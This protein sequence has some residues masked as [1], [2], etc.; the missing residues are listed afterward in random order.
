VRGLLA[1]LLVASLALTAA[2]QEEPDQNLDPTDLV[3][4][5]L[6]GLLGFGEVSGPQL[7]EEVAQIGGVPFRSDVPLAYLDKPALSRYLEELFD[8]EY[9]Q[10]QADADARTLRGLDLL[11]P[12]TDL[13]ALRRR[14][15]LENVAG[16]YDERPG[17]RRLYAVST[18]QALTPANQIIMAHELRHA[19]QDQYADL[20]GLFPDSVGDFDDRKMALLC[21]LEGDATLVM[22]KFLLARVPGG[23]ELGG[24]ALALPTPPVDGA[25][26][27]LRDQL[28]RP[29]TLGLEFARSVQESRG[30]SALQQ[31]WASP[32]PSTEQI[33]HPEKF[34]AGERPVAVSLDWSPAGGRVLRDGVLGEVFAS[35]LVDDEPGNEAT[36]GWGGDVVRSW[37][38]AGRTL[39]VFRS[40]WDSEADRAQ[41]ATALLQRFRAH[42]GTGFPRGRAQVFRSGAW[43]F[44]LTASGDGEVQLIGSDDMALLDQALVALVSPQ[45]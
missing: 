14:L 1:A 41:F 2:A 8:D 35:S 45:S 37:D 24:E 15:L 25:P 17:R 30:W 33:L 11:D 5:L 7:Q 9:P 40:V 26:D 42:H 3:N 18:Q 36:T 21:V 22:Q 10:S 6:S 39:V 38:V 31:A 16:F 13:R 34:A 23:E 12:A 29:Y 32:P 43:Q 20:H 27:V 19:L 44:A 28:V 4:V